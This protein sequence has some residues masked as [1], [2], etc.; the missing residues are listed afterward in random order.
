MAS[1]LLFSLIG[2]SN[3]KRNM[4]PTACRDRPHMM[5]AQVLLCSRLEVF[6]QSLKSIKS[7]SNVCVV[8]CLS[9]FISSS[10][11]T[12]ESV[13]HRVGP[14]LDEVFSLLSEEC[15]SN[16]QRR[17]LVSPPMYRRSPMWYRDGMAEILKKFSAMAA[18]YPQSNLGLLPSFSS[19]ALEADGVHLTPYSG[20]E[21]VLH[22]FDSAKLLLA[23]LEAPQETRQSAANE[24]T[25]L[26]EDRVVALEQDHRRLSSEVD[27][28]TAIKAELDDVVINERNEDSFIIS[29]LP[30][31]SGRLTGK[32]WQ[33]RAQADVQKIIHIIMG[34]ALPILVVHNSTGPSPTAEVSYSVQMVRV[35]DAKALR[36]K[37][38]S[39]FRGGID[40]RPEA[41]SRVS[42]Q[43]LVTRAT[44]VRAL[45]R[46]IYD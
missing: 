4:T 12:S 21:Y 22:L 19:A 10:E 42:I 35:E 20:L 13:S 43:N 34:S 31:I 7:E 44:R 32:D 1:Q 41:L 27:L 15:S 38:G 9:N 17:Y 14:I 37:F 36:F 23:S 16:V 28:S 29:G 30:R 25:R 33:E 26:L 24:A 45:S 3:V 8:A 2:D 6:K 11:D 5:S 46:I 18:A 39:Y 40:A